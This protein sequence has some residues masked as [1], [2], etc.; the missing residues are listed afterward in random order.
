MANTSATQVRRDHRKA[1]AI[2]APE[3]KRRH[4]EI[5]AAKREGRTPDLPDDSIEWMRSASHG[6]KY[7]EVNMQLGLAIA[8]IHTTSDLLTQAMLNLC[9]HPE[10]VVPL[11]Q[12]VLD[13]LG[14]YGWQKVALTELRL[15]DS[16]F[17]ETQRLKP[18]GMAVMH[19]SAVR[20]VEL[21]NGVRIYKGEHI[22]VSSHRMW[23]PEEY[24]DPESFDAFRFAER[25]KMPGYENKSLLVATSP[26]HMAFSHGKHACPGRFF[27]AN[28]VKI[29]MVHI[30]LKY[31]LKIADPSYAQWKCFG[32]NMI[33][34][35][36]AKIMMKSRVPELDLD[37]LALEL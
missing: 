9:A 4:E 19:R 14:K 20:D 33:P 22:A 30:L 2:I 23:D 37:K 7:H 15:L 32:V 34:N 18:V 17:K 3:I 25:R 16:F 10:A 35:P 28:E 21:P 6:R 1:A 8:A 13:V 12:E 29:A 36:K 11:R 26:D 27:A 5:A 24:K 31:D